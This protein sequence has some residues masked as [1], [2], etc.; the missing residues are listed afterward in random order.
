MKIYSFNP[1]INETI[2]FLKTTEES[3][4][5]S[6]EMEI[7][8]GK[9]ASGPPLHVHPA[10]TEYYKV[11]KGELKAYTD[12]EWKTLKE[13]EELTIAA[14]EVHTFDK[15]ATDEV[16]FFNSFYPALSFERI[17]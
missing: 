4:G 12:G 1:F 7:T 14:G 16:V 15:G 3:K 2:R 11:L 10:Q 8:L 6:L 9:R 13:G 5:A 17:F